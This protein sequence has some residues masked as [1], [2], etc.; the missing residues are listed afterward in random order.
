[1]KSEVISCA[2]CNN[3]I[4]LVKSFR[5]QA[6]HMNDFFKELD[7][8]DQLD[9]ETFDEIRHRFGLL[10]D[11]DQYEEHIEAL[12][13]AFEEEGTYE[14]IDE[15]FEVEEEDFTAPKEASSEFKC[16]VCLNEFNDIEHLE[17][18]CHEIHN[19]PPR[20][21][22]SCGEILDSQKRL[23]SH[24]TKH[25]NEVDIS[26]DVCSLS[27][28]STT[29][30]EKHKKM[31]HGKDAERFICSKC[32][33][34][35]KDRQLLK[36]HGRSH[37][38]DD[39]KLKVPCTKCDK[40]FVNNHCMKIHVMRIH[41]K[42]AIFTCETCSKTFVTR[43]DFNW[44]RDK[45]TNERNFECDICKQMFKSSN[46]LRIH[47]RRHLNENKYICK[48]CGKEFNSSA[49]LSNHK[50]VHSDVKRYKCFCGNEYKRLE[51]YKCHL[52]V[53]SGNRPFSCQWCSRTF[54][55]SANCRKHKLKEHP[56]EVKEF[57]LIHGKRGV[58][59]A[60]KKKLDT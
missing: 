22:C 51:S 21:T 55:N 14:F 10:G 54:V 13:E 9:A 36:N 19:T 42:C 31:K 46:S 33:K 8:Q 27:Y 6:I 29:A 49:A 30:Y 3:L 50:L 56:I 4:G 7:K 58:S 5:T 11:S 60:M 23:I 16:H 25:E 52:S 40:K 34:E 26:C 28:K 44:H 15:N 39:L 18:H 37:L 43:S 32:G 41:E 17:N 57:E 20:V 12:D 35:F 38:P 53:H 48:Q 59:L 2:E 47:K 1:M 45:H 24:Q